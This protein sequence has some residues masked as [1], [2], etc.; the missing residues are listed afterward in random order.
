VWSYA[1]LPL[2]DATMLSLTVVIWSLILSSIVCNEHVL[3]AQWLAAIAGLVGAILVIR[4]GFNADSLT[5]TIVFLGT[6]L[7]G[8][9][10]AMN[11]RLGRDDP[12]TTTMF[13]ANV[14][15]LVIFGGSL[16]TVELSDQSLIALLTIGPVGMLLGIFAL[17]YANLGT[18]APT[19]LIRVT[20]TLAI[21]VVWFGEMLSI[22]AAIGAAIILASVWIAATK[23]GKNQP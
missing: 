6:S 21:A 5:Y 23:L 13:Y 4:P 10:M 14:V 12:S 1:H 19:Q 22:V 7:N 18:V 16:S 11:R 20:L 8:L 15:P 2:A 3:L 9:A 17:Q